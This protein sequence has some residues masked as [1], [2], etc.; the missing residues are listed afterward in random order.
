MTVKQTANPDDELLYHFTI[1]VR[2]KLEVWKNNLKSK[3]I[4]NS[5]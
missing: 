2:F 5:P 1:R 4:L 3:G